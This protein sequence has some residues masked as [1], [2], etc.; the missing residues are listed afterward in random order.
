MRSASRGSATG[1]PSSAICVSRFSVTITPGFGPTPGS[2]TLASHGET[3]SITCIGKIGGH[4]V[5]GRG[6][7]GLDETYT[8]GS[9]LSHV[10]TGT[11]RVSL[12]T[13]A[14]V[15]HMV[16]AATSRRSGLGLLAEVRFRDARFRG[17]GVAVPTQ[18]NCLLTPLRRAL[19]TVSGSLNATSAVAA[20]ASRPQPRRRCPLK[21]ASYMDSRG[22]RRLA[23]GGGVGG[24]G[25]TSCLTRARS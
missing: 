11:V 14:G 21:P 23:E 1:G 5:T 12:P 4:R 18:G 6:S 24:A 8:R 13:S 19:I 9:C 3:G 22:S 25:G 20:A 2:G 7:V 17:V 10:G 16:G 15:K